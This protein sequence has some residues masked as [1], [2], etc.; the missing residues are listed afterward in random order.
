MNCCL[1]NVTVTYINAPALTES[2]VCLLVAN[3][4]NYVIHQPTTMS[5][6]T[7]HAFSASLLQAN[8]QTSQLQVD[9]KDFFIKEILG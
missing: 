8:F 6:L 4:T 1:A 3:L 5:L 9:E 7:N 2:S